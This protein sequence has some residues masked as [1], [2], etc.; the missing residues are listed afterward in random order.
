MAGINRSLL[1]DNLRR[2]VPQAAPS[3]LPN[4]P[5]AAP[6]PQSEG[7]GLMATVTDQSAAGLALGTQSTAI[8]TSTDGV[9][10]FQAAVR[11]AVAA[12]GSTVRLLV[13]P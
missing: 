8:F 11:S 12:D 4:L 9:F 1:V 6:I 5:P 2:L 3:S 13:A 10:T 7:V